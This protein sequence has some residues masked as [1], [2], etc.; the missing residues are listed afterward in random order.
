VLT[1]LLFGND[2]LMVDDVKKIQDGTWTP[3]MRLYGLSTGVVSIADFHGLVPDDVA[4]KVEQAKQDI[5]S[6]KL[7][8]PYI[9]TQSK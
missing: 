6:G 3:E 9:T 7:E 4:K 5:I 2:K 1:S 8:V